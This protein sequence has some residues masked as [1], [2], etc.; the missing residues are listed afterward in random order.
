MEMGGERHTP[1]ALPP[2][3]RPGTHCVGEWVDLRDGL[4]GC[5]KFRPHWDSILEPY[6]PQ[7]VPVPT[8]VSRPTIHLL[9][10]AST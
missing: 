3:R 2:E 7:R 1:A 9:S 4:D 10:S 8:E 6:S 5:G